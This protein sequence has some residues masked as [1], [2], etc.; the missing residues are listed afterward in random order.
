MLD[1][2]VIAFDETTGNVHAIHVQ[3]QSKEH[4]FFVSAQMQP[5]LEYVACI[6][7]HHNESGLL[8]WPGQGVVDGETIL[9]NAS[10]AVL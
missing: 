8:G 3:A 10:E 4:A 6:I 2:T 1:Y 5:E 7:G 9:E